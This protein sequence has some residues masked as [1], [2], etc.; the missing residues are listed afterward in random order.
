MPWS[1]SGITRAVHASSAGAEILAAGRGFIEI[2]FDS[3]VLV[4]LLL[5]TTTPAALT[6]WS[7]GQAIVVA[8]PEEAATGLPTLAQTVTAIRG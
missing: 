7:L 8:P 4:L 2:A 3:C 6:L 5:V 1:S